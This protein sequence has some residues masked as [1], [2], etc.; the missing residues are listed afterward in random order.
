MS[1]LSVV[2]RDLSA[3]S[4][5][6]DTANPT[7]LGSKTG[8]CRLRSLKMSSNLLIVNVLSPGGLT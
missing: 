6:F 7:D 8:Y 3:L 4:S 5:I 1:S 2:L